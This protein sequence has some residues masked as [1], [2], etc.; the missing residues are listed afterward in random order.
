MCSPSPSFPFFPSFCPKLQNLA[1]RIVSSSLSHSFCSSLL[2]HII[3]KLYQE[4]KLATGLNISVMHLWVP[5]L[6]M[7]Q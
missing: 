5:E 4:R 2:F 6:K 1:A 7:L 3:C